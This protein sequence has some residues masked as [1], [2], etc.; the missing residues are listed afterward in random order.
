MEE[1]L[2]H[3]IVSTSAFLVYFSH[4][5]ACI[6]LPGEQNMEQ[7]EGILTLRCV[8]LYRMLL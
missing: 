2:W 8:L 3:Y 1:P 5:Y 4:A 6:L 7:F